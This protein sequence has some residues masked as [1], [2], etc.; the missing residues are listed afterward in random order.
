MAGI[1]AKEIA[2]EVVTVFTPEKLST[3]KRVCVAVAG[4]GIATSLAAVCVAGVKQNV[5]FAKKATT[6]V[7]A[8]F[9]NDMLEE[10]IPPVIEKTEETNPIEIKEPAE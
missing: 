8:F 7:T 1:G 9:N 2:K 6:R 3:G 4:S 10:D 5:D